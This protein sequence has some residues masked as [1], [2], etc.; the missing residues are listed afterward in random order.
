[1]KIV[2]NSVE[3]CTICLK[4]RG[5]KKITLAPKNIITKGS[6]E[7][8]V[9]DGW[10]LHTELSIQ[11][12]FA[13]VIDIID[14]YSKYLGSYPI[15]QNNA[16]NVLTAVKEFCFFVGFPKII[17]TDNGLEYDNNIFK[18]FCNK[19]KITHIKS[20]PRH[21]QTNGVVEIVHREIRKFIIIKY[22]EHDIN[23]ILKNVLLDAINCHNHNIH[24][25]TG[26][27]PC[28]L[29]NNTDDNI[30]NLV[31]NNIN[32]SLKN[33]NNDEEDI[34]IGNHILINQKVHLK[35]K[36]LVLAKFKAKD[37]LFKIPATIIAHYG[38]GLLAVKID[39]S[40]YELEKGQECIIDYNLCSLID[41]TQWNKILTES[42][43]D[44]NVKPKKIKK[45]RKVNY[46]KD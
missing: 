7:R 39:L 37:K 8:Y 16:V 28:D 42:E 40:N 44:V 29:I 26:F 31:L 15:I 25:S 13:W 9:V 12:G 24:T 46:P 21:P 38:G 18:E 10:K 32:K 11:S 5:G 22:S 3:N 4:I 36:K 17:Q 1:M 2:K 19:Y 6:R 34:K 45:F 27:R 20:K 23:F 33:K 35:G 41:E 43:K 30:R 14:Y